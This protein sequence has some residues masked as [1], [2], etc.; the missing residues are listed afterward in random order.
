MDQKGSHG[1]DAEDKGRN[2]MTSQ[3]RSDQYVC[4][5]CEQSMPLDEKDQ[6][7]DW[8]FAKDLQEQETRS[9]S[10]PNNNPVLPASQADDEPPAFSPPSYPPPNG[11]SRA[12]NNY[13]NQVI[14]AA[15][16]RARDEV[17]LVFRVITI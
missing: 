2:S 9:D 17:H 11:V 13:T 14:E 7:Q 6:H 15:K 16:L 5:R 10:S 12:A 1:S 3:Q 4:T 8:H